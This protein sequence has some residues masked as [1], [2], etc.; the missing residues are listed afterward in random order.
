[1]NGP[2]PSQNRLPSDGQN[3]KVF[4]KFK[5]HFKGATGDDL[6]KAMRRRRLIQWVAFLLIV[7]CATIGYTVQKP[8]R[9]A[10]LHRGAEA[11]LKK[12]DYTAAT[13]QARRALQI[14]P[15][16]VTACE[17]MAQI[18]EHDHLPDAVSWRERVL[19]LKGESA[20][21]L[22]AFATSALR[23]G[24]ISTARS[25]LERVPDNDRGREE[26]LVSAG[27]IIL[28]AGDHEESARLYEAATRLNPDKTAYRLALGRARCASDDYLIRE[29][30]RRLLLDLGSDPKLGVLA[31]R[32]LIA[33]CE[34]HQESQAALRHASQLVAL[35]AHEFSD[36]VLRL[37]LMRNTGDKK[38]AGALA[39]AQE[40]ASGQPGH[41]SILL[42]WMSRAG[43][44]NEGLDWMLNREPKFF[45]S[46]E[47]R[48]AIASCYLTQADWNALL[49]FTAGGAW[50]LAD[51]VRHAYRARAFREQSENTLSRNE[52]NFAVEAAGRKV[53]A[54]TWLAQTSAEWKWTDETEQC[55]WALL[56]VAPSTRWAVTSLQ[57]FYLQHHNTLGLHRVSAHQ[58]K[59]D[60]ADESAR[61]NYA[62][63][64][65]LLNDDPERAIK[66]ARELHTKNPDNIAFISTYAFALHCA[67]RTEDGLKL[68]EKLP[69][70]RLED[71]AIAAYYG[72]M[73]AANNAPEKAAHF[74]EIGRS[75]N[76]LREEIALIARA[77]QTIDTSK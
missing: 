50:R 46:Q 76:L 36:E 4:F 29:E 24:K 7:A 56:K 26:F 41:A 21:T 10:S 25:A 45:F 35:P 20:D 54:L 16:D 33:N 13:F 34:A 73:L 31:L 43:L 74:L 15:N 44:V 27:A 53:E 59:A 9:L 32:I 51:H 49:T 40:K 52:W 42:L 2:E 38:F 8:W 70:E 68:L 30:G 60:P 72:I 64:S 62:L 1:M 39:E 22:L 63:I 71:P 3:D 48:P 61:N 77:E 66:I 18:A 19:H 23:F 37:R 58:M 57:A 12:G 11:S 5:M 69:P 28:E 14:D 6:A 65:L 17:T 55:L 75:G 67:N 47:L